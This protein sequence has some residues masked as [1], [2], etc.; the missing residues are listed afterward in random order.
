MQI[1]ISWQ[2]MP[3]LLEHTYYFL[4]LT[5]IHV[6]M[7]TPAYS[8]EQ[9]IQGSYFAVFGVFPYYTIILIA[10]CA[11]FVLSKLSRII[12]TY[13]PIQ[14]PW[15]KWHGFQI[16]VKASIKTTSYRSGVIKHCTEYNCNVLSKGSK[17]DKFKSI[18]T[19]LTYFKQKLSIYNFCLLCVEKYFFNT[20]IFQRVLR[21]YIDI[22]LSQ[23]YL[24]HFE[25]FLVK[26]HETREKTALTCF[27]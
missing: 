4:S 13:N 18:F 11:V 19:G 24:T 3:C 2:I 12:K 23:K 22:F 1:F 16:M 17:Q 26:V 15:P 7:D 20:S 27:V 21:V 14:E 25:N 9:L 8:I 6:H 5:H 10:R